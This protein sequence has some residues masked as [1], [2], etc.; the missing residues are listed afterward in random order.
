MFDI[1]QQKIDFD[2]PDCGA[3]N[4]ITLEQAQNQET[5]VCVGCKKEI[6]L[7]DKDGSVNKS[8]S[9]I[10]KAAKE[11]ENTIKKFGKYFYF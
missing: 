9:D 6:K 1:S 3:K 8:V 2:C 5:I 10:N 7:T 11:L 4:T